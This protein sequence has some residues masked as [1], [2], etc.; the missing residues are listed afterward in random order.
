MDTHESTPYALAVGGG[1]LLVALIGVGPQPLFWALVGTTLGLSA[2]VQ[3]SRLRACIVFAASVFAAAQLGLWAGPHLA[4]T[5]SLAANGA[6]L[7]LGALLQPVLAGA[8]AAVPGVFAGLL[9]RV[10][11][12]GSETSGSERAGSERGEQP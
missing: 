3:T 11:L 7:V 8:T 1:A 6:S 10:G 9:R 12:S 5:S 2:S 4:G